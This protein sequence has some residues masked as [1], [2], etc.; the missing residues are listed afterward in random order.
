MT[1][2]NRDMYVCEGDRVIPNICRSIF[3]T[4]ERLHTETRRHSKILYMADQAHTTCWNLMKLEMH[5]ITR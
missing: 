5:V 1:G 3:Y 4:T 2:V